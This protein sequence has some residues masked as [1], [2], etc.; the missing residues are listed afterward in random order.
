M[1]VNILKKEFLVTFLLTNGDKINKTVSANAD[2]NYADI[3]KL[4]IIGVDAN[5]F[6]ELETDKG[7]KI[8]LNENNIVSITAEEI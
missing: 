1:E 7:S 3:Y 4:A 8:M 5:N 2:T 6:Y